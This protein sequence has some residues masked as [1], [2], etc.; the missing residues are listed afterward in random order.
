MNLVKDVPENQN[1]QIAVR[2]ILVAV[3]LIMPFGIMSKSEGGSL[4]N[5]LVLDG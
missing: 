3:R 5:T 2:L 4:L 1:A